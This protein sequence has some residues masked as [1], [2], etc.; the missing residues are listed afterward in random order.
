MCFIAQLR[1]NKIITINIDSLQIYTVNQW[2]KL[3]CLLYISMSLHNLNSFLMFL[4]KS[5]LLTKSAFIWLKIQ[6]KQ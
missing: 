4:K 2:D 1:Y 6:Q 5:L 3:V